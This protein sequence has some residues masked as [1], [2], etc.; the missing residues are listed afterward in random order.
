MPWIFA[1]GIIAL[2]VF[3]IGFRRFTITVSVIGIILVVA[4]AVYVQIDSERKYAQANAA[5][6][7]LP[8]CAGKDPAQTYLESG[9]HCR[10][11]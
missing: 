11:P 4:L 8:A 9:G 6:A 7:S 1:L 2:C 10:L 5:H 3:S